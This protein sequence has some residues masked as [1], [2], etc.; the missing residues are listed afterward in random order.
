MFTLLVVNIIVKHMVVR[1]VLRDAEDLFFKHLRV[2]YINKNE[3]AFLRGDR[4]INV[5]QKGNLKDLTFIRMHLLKVL[6][7]FKVGF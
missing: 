4:G 1:N 2:T 7:L 5:I 6:L 3:I